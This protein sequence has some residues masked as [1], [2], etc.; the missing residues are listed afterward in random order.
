LAP[1]RR[2]RRR[3]PQLPPRPLPQTAGQH[4]HDR[5]TGDLVTKQFLATADEH[6]LPAS[7][8]TDNGVV[9]T[10]RFVGGKNTFEYLLA[11]LGIQQRNGHPGQTQ[12]KIERLHQTL[13]R[14]L[15]QQPPAATLPALQ[16]QLD[17]FRQLYNQHRPHRALDRA[18]P[19]QAYAARP[20]A[21]P[22]GH[23]QPGHYRLRYDTLDTSAR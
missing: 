5:V 11:A 18:T 1:S 12:G 19:D 16:R 6:G 13:K 22:P 4:R 3:D 15:A 21:A 20:K 14:W 8:L 17:T 2:H 7:T 23:G 10:A 9:Y